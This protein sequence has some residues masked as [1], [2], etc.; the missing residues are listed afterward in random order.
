MLNIFFSVT[1]RAKARQTSMI[2]S[3]TL[4]SPRGD[5][6]AMQA[7]SAYNIPHTGGH[8]TYIIRRLHVA[9]SKPIDF[10]GS[11]RSTSSVEM[12]VSS[13]NT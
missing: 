4:A 2:T 9:G 11:I 3:I 10:G 7:S 6:E 5:R 13:L 1:F 8:T 12:P